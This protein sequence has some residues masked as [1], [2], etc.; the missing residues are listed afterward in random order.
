MKYGFRPQYFQVALLSR[1]SVREHLY[2]RE[3]E[4]RNL[5]VRIKI[6]RNYTSSAVPV[7]STFLK[8][9]DALILVT[10]TGVEP[11]SSA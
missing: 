6:N 2:W 1:E 8:A 10:P 9:Q 4:D 3:E 5:K 7:A 11:V